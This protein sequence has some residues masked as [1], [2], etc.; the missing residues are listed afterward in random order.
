[1]N[2]ILIVDD[3]ISVR[4]TLSDILSYYGYETLAVDCGQKAINLI[5][6]KIPDLVLLDIMLEDM[7]G[8]DVLR[9]IK[10]EEE[11]TEFIILTGNVS[12]EAVVKA[13][14]LGAY[15]Y[16]QKPYDIEQLLIM[17][18]RAIEKQNTRK[19]LFES[20]KRY[21]TLFDNVND[22]IFIYDLE[23]IFLEVNHIA[24]ERF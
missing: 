6:E 13:I 5:K 20:E 14:N 1:M 24:C 4:K 9:E 22:A 15:G 17:I 19:E 16:I 21:R 23:G 12:Q 3:E 18:K 10:K 7:S 8:I 2:S 11:Y